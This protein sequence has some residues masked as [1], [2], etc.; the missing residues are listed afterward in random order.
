MDVQEYYKQRLEHT[1]QH[2]QQATNLIYLVNG[3]ILAMFYFVVRSPAQYISAVSLLLVLAVVNFAHAAL[4]VRQ[5][6]WYRNI[7]QTFA[8]S[9]PEITK[10]EDPKGLPWISS[11]TLFASVHAGLCL[12]LALAAFAICRHPELIPKI[13]PG[14]T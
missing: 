7:D 5:G 2:T 3:A 11:H 10:I 9:F 13:A 4:I 12:L 6:K 1:L 14:V 8:D